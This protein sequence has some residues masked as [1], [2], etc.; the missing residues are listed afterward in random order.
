MDKYFKNS[1]ISLR[2]YLSYFFKKVAKDEVLIYAEALT[3]NTLLAVIPLLGLVFSFARAIIPEDTLI[4]KSFELLVKLLPEEVAGF[5][6]EK[7]IYFLDRIKHFPLGKFSLLTYF[8]MSIGLLFFVEGC[9]NRI[10]LSTEKRTIRERIS[11]FWLTLTIA[12]FILLIPIVTHGYLEARLKYATYLLFIFMAFVFYLIYYYF[13]VRKVPR[14]YALISSFITTILW[15]IL[16]FGFSLYVK[17]AVS[18]SA[19]YGSLS[20]IF[21]FFLWIFLNWLLFLLGAELTV[22]LS[23][24]HNLFKPK[25]PCGWDRII[26]LKTIYENFL[27]CKSLSLERLEN[28]LN[29]A[30][31]RLY[32]LLSELEKKGHILIAEGLV[33]PTRDLGGLKLSELLGLTDEVL[34][35][36]KSLSVLR[37][38]LEGTRLKDIID[39]DERK[40]KL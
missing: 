3:F 17:Y 8:I 6:V 29:I 26:L 4:I 15:G 35:E 38:F 1:I 5:V 9:L 7:L 32:E 27:K 22:F 21:F 28:T 12:P 30:P 37:D 19:I 33:L 18:Y 10:Y 34:K 2:L 36:A 16:S 24:R 40:C 13:P 23:L 31:D 39:E 11:F 25:L 14:K 20:T